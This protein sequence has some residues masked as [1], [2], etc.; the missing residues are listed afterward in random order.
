MFM[1]LAANSVFA[2]GSLI[3]ALDL[4]VDYMLRAVKRMSEEGIKSMS[5]KPE[6]YVEFDAFQREFNKRT[7][8]QTSCKFSLRSLPTTNSR[9]I[10]TRISVGRSWYKSN[11]TDVSGK[12]RLISS[13]LH[14]NN[15]LYRG[16]LSNIP[17]QC[18]ISDRL[19]SAFDGKIT[20]SSIG[21]V[22]AS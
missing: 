22:I 1:S 13:G 20:L 4:G 16:K 10:L 3:P 11:T 15:R 18:Y 9:K 6:A 8:W 21:L 7:V 2:H 17:A 14:T 19:W 12:L 5:L